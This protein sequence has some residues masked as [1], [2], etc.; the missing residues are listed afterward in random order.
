M[1]DFRTEYILW[2][3]RQKKLCAKIQEGPYMYLNHNLLDK[4]VK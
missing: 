2:K 1:K 3:I 4:T